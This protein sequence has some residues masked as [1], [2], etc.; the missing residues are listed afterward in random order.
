MSDCYDLSPEELREAYAPWIAMLEE[1]C[2]TF[3][4][5][6]VN[7]RSDCHAWASLLCYEMPAVILGVRPVEPGFGQVLIRPVVGHLSFASG[8]VP[9]PKGAVWVSWKKDRSGKI[10]L[11]YHLPEG[12]TEETDA[13]VVISG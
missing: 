12:M 1:N 11:Q 4:E 8:S 5:T 6:P 10:S 3:P 13:D 7:P 2:T 9:T